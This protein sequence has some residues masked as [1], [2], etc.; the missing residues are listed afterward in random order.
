MRL[1]V[2]GGK[3]GVGKT[4]V[5]MNLG[6]ELNAVVVDGDL[7][8]ADLPQTTGPDLHDV[9]AGRADP[10]EAL[11]EFNSLTVLPC[12]R[13]LEGARASDLSKLESVVE[14]LERR[15]GNVLIDSPAGLAR[16]VGTILELADATVLV[17]T[18]E[19]TALADAAKTKELALDLDTPIAAVALNKVHSEGDAV[20]SS[21]EEVQDRFNA[22]AVAIPEQTA[23]AES[24]ERDRLITEYAPENPATE[25]FA[26]LGWILQ[27]NREWTS[28]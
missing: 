9:L 19:P 2:S 13:S 11:V 4:T 10:S 26:E 21:L 25:Q 5:S 12:G 27:R 28:S 20:Q 7:T 24:Q 23:I 3:G 22:S 14:T 16:D 15:H 1:A 17:T 18:P 6:V 8:N